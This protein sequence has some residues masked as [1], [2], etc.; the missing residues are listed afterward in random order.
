MHLGYLHLTNASS[1][2]LSVWREAREALESWWVRW[3]SA[4]RRAAASRLVRRSQEAAPGCAK[5]SLLR[6]ERSPCADR[7]RRDSCI[8]AEL[9]TVSVPGNRWT[10]FYRR[11]VVRDEIETNDLRLRT[12]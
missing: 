8:E 4:G 5:G 2:L 11:V 7:A 6:R 1:V 9:S 12:I 10:D 3:G